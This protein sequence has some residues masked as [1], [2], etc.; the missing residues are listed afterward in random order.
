[1]SL[2]AR[3]LLLGEPDHVAMLVTSI[4]SAVW[5]FSVRM[6]NLFLLR[7]KI[8]RVNKRITA[9]ERDEH[10]TDVEESIKMKK[11]RTI[12]LDAAERAGAAVLVYCQNLGGDTLVEYIGTNMSMLLVVHF[13]HTKV[14][15]FNVA[16]T[17]T[18]TILTPLACAACPRGDL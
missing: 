3:L 8:A 12:T 9:H 5:E 10:D 2:Q 7:R 4:I 11:E 15:A 17:S 18:S 14:F 1:M 6:A 13:G 16:R